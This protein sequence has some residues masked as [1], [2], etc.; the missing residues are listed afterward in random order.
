MIVGTG[1]D[2][3]EVDRIRKSIE[4][5]G[6]RFVE[7]IFTSREI[8][9]VFIASSTDTHADYLRRAARAG[10]AVLCEKPIDLAIDRARSPVA[11][12]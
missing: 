4:R 8:D 5:Y 9:A 2:L 11:A 6:A 3:A 10:K 12:S 7:R 1:V